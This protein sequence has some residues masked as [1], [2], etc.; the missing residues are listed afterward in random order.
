MSATTAAVAQLALLVGALAAVH[1]PLG[2]YLARVYS[3]PRHLRIE[4]VVYRAAGVDADA[5]QRWPVYI[6]SV[7]A[8]SLVS[9]LAL[10]ALQRGQALLPWSRDLPGVQP[11]TAWNTAASFVTNTNWQSY[12]GESTMGHLVQM[13]GLSVQNF[14]SAAVGLA[15]AVAL[16]RGFARSRTDRIGNFWTDVTRGTFRVLLPLAVA[17]AT[18]LVI[19]GVV[20]SI[21]TDVQ[22]TTLT[23]GSQ[24]IVTGPVASQESIKELG[25]NGGGFFNANSAHPFEGPSAW[26]SLFQVFLLLVIPFSLPRTFGRLV[27][28]LRQGRAILAVMAGLWLVAASLLTAAELRPAGAVPMAAA[29]ALEGKEVRFGE[30]LSALFAASTTGTSTGAVNAAH[31]SLTAA[32][33]GIAMAS[34]MLG[35]VTP[36]GVGSGLYGMLVLAILAVFLA[37]LMVGR[38]PEYLAKKVGRREVTFVALYVLAVPTLLLL[39][40]AVTAAVPELRE[41]SVQEPGPHGLSEVLYAYAS[42]AN[43]NG[44]AF[45]GFNAATGFQNVAL[46]LVMLLGRFVPIVLVLALAGSLA[47]QRPLSTS[48]GSLPTHTPVFVGLLAFVTVVVAG[49]TYFPALSL[50]PIAEA[51]S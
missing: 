11:A 2:D 7:L 5:D 8:F 22:V 27:G 36:G 42:A 10:Y 45:A 50:A 13:A 17:G 23:G 21:G 48:E 1:H 12:A 26:V 29:A 47:Q 6:R 41:A 44:S 25:T 18:V 24:T 31:D 43:N 14:L 9:L 33:G 28:D 46:G 3:S 34:M 51:L 40:A 35:E 37:G 49:L 38:T 15:V 4:R 19:G 32:G 30:A 39:G 16:V 20:Q